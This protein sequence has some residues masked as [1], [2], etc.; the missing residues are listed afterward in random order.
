MASADAFSGK[1]LH[2][3]FLNLSNTD[4]AKLQ[5][6]TSEDL[7]VFAVPHSP[8]KLLPQTETA[9]LLDYIS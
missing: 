4:E 5:W 6:L 1:N 2:V 8:H 9:E 7:R 3:P